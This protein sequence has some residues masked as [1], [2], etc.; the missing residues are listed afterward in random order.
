METDSSINS[1]Y[2][3]DSS[4]N[5]YKIMPTHYLK[6]SPWEDGEDRRV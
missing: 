3:Q 5:V 1:K 6:L 2:I 4:D